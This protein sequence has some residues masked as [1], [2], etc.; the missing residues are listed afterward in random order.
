ME[1][2]HLF[3]FCCFKPRLKRQDAM[4]D[5]WARR[6]YLFR[7]SE[8]SHTGPFGGASVKAHYRCTPRWPYFT[9][10]LFSFQA[11]FLSGRGARWRSRDTSMKRHRKQAAG[12]ERLGKQPCLLLTGPICPLHLDQHEGWVGGAEAPFITPLQTALVAANYSN[13]NLDF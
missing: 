7:R 4:N 1:S 9:R 8:I 2:A 6:H 5:E 13:I 3:I 10:R 11:Q 12:E